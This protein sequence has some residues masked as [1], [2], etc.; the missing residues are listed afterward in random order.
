MRCTETRGFQQIRQGKANFA[1]IGEQ[2]ET[3]EENDSEPV[4]YHAEIKVLE[5]KEEAVCLA[6][7]MASE[8]K[9]VPLNDIFGFE[10][11][12]FSGEGKPRK[13]RRQRKALKKQ[14]RAKEQ[15]STKNDKE[16]D[17]EDSG[18]I[19]QILCSLL[20]GAEKDLKAKLQPVPIIEVAFSRIAMD[21]ID[22]IEQAEEQIHFGN[23]RLCDMVSRGN[24]ARYPEVLTRYGIPR[25]VLTDQ[26]SN[27]ADL[28]QSVFKLMN[29]LHIK[30]SPMS[31]HP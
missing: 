20:E 19:L 10:E 12:M 9:P 29:V 25:E 5:Q 24:S 1:D 18:G 30:T 16:G 13:S 22:L 28:L 11:D 15:L 2:L 17:V 26:G 23:L 3:E 27:M 6:K 21:M 7:E 14:W 8:A 4:E 31:Y